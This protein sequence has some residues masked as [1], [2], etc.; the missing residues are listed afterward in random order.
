MAIISKVSLFCA[1][2]ALLM[3]AHPARLFAA[4]VMPG[5]LQTR[6]QN[7]FV[8]ASGLPLAPAVP[9][10]GSWQ[11]DTTWTVANTELA[12][13][14]PDSNMT[15]DAESDEFR[16]SAAYAFNDQWSLRGSV[17]Y[18]SIGDGFLDSTIENYH[19]LFGFTNGDRGL[20]G[21]EAPFIQ[22]DLD[23]ETLYLLDRNQSGT[24]PLFMDLTRSWSYG[25]GKLAGITLGSKWPIGSTSKLTDTGSTD[26]SLSMF[27]QFDTGERLTLG[28]RVGILV[29]P[30]NELL[31]AQSKTSVGFANLLLRVRLD[32]NW[33]FLA[34]YDAHEEL[35]KNLPAFFQ[36]SGQASF[37]FSRRIGDSTELQAIF[38]EDVPRLHTTDIAF[39]FNLR[40]DLGQHH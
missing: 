35:Y 3:A 13:A 8:L 20:L 6:D 34:Q 16:F 26:F 15:F 11:L 25:D 18:L 40:V 37:G 17:S 9:P 7:P 21:T 36:A 12:Q 1:G 29:Q 4:D 23:G 30:D 27:T 2:A 24:G 39:G 14:I 19:R 32:Q 33:S 10:P 31:G 28:A 22:V 5:W 38:S